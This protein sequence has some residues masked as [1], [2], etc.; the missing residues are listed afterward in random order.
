MFVPV[1]HCPSSTLYIPVRLPTKQGRSPRQYFDPE[2]QWKISIFN[3][4]KK[5]RFHSQ[6]IRA[7]D[8]SFNITTM[9]K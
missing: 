5:A 6:V 7:R 9:L 3:G 2:Y 1:L 8:A 4:R